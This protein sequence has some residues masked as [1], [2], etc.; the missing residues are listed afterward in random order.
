[1]SSIPSGF[2]TSFWGLT[3]RISYLLLATLGV[4]L[5]SVPLFSQGTFGRILGT[6]T[7]QSGGV[8][9]GA[10]VTIIDKDRG[11]AR[12]LTSDDAGEY[13]APNLTPGTYIVRVEANGFKKLERENVELGVGKEVRV[14]LT[15]QPGTQAQTV[16]VTEAIPLVE[17]TNATLGGTLNNEQIIDL[18]LNGR[19]YQNLMG[20]RPGVLLQPGGSPWTQSTNGGRP[21]QTAWMIEGVINEAFFDARPLQG[22]PSPF[23]DGATIVPIDA[24]QEFNMQE[25]PKAEYGWRPGAVVNVG[26]KNGT[27]NLHGTAYAFGRS[28]ALDARNAFNENLD[29][30][31]TCTLNGEK[32]DTDGVCN[33]A[34]AQLKQFGGTV[35]GPIKKDKLFFFAGY[36]GLRSQIGNIFILP[37]PNQGLMAQAIAKVQGL[38]GFSGTCGA[39]NAG[40]GTNRPNPC[41]S[42]VSLALAGCTPTGAAYTC[43]GGGSP[44]PGGTFVPSTTGLFGEQH[45][46]TSA[47]TTYSS[48][49]PNQNTS[50]NGIFK[51]DYHINNKNSLTAS[52]LVGNYT[53][54]GEDHPIANSYWRD[55]VPIRAQTYTG[56][57]IF[58]PSSNWVNDLRVA[59]DR[60]KFQI[61]PADTSLLANG[62]NYPLNTGITSTGG[63][64]TVYLSGAS[65]F[66]VAGGFWLGSWRGR[67]LITGP[68]PYYDLQDSVSYLRGK[69]SFK[70]GGEFAHI[71]VDEAPS[72][73]RGRFDIAGGGGPAAQVQTL[74][75]FFSG[76]FKDLQQI[77]GNTGRKLH[78][79]STAGFIQ[80]DYR[81]TSKLM[82]NLGLRYSYESPFKDA[83][84]QL[85][86]FDPNS[87]TGLVQQGQSGVN[88]ILNPDR[89]D[90][91]PRLGFAWDVTGKG[92]TV[93]RGGA[94]IIY[95][96]WQMAAFL[97]NPGPSGGHDHGASLALD[98]TG[99]SCTVGPGCPNGTYGGNITTGTLVLPGSSVHWDSSSAAPAV[100][101]APSCI[102]LTTGK[103]VCDLG[104]VDP[105]MKYPYVINWNLGVTHAFNPNLSLELGYVG[106]HGDRLT[107]MRD[108]NQNEVVNGQTFIDPVTGNPVQPYAAQFPGFRYINYAYGGASSNYDGL[109]TTL[110]Q[111]TSHG[112]SFTAG[113][114]YSHALDNGSLN[115]FGAL[116]Q[117]GYDLLAE[118]GS[119]DLDVRHHFTFTAS[120]D[121][122]GKK[123]FGQMLEGWKLNTVV[124]LQ[125][126]LPWGP[127][128][129][130]NDFENS[131]PAGGEET[132]RW[133]F[134]GNPADFK[135]P[136]SSNL[137]YCTGPG[138]GGCTVTSGISGLVTPFSDAQSTAMW[139]QCVAKA[140]DPAGTL[141]AGGCFVSGNSVM[142][143]PA[144]NHFGNMGRN[145]FRD[146]GFRDWDFSVFKNFRFT[147]RFGAQFRFEVF[148]LL[149]HP[150]FANPYG[151]AAG[152]LGSD[153]ST[154]S[155]FGCGCTTPDVGNGNALL[156]SGSARV[157]QLGLKLSF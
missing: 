141:A 27:N 7:D 4:L 26:L 25:N 92:T 38:P 28:D 153:P 156:G 90:F 145:L 148:N 56:D 110:T 108:L 14:D 152:G 109:Q 23:T 19:L 15:V 119:S 157:M 151:A 84:N 49:F 31:G 63:M 122:P 146:A 65:G 42:P 126:G 97:A 9:S 21:D 29:P 70:F 124:T 133:D 43:L 12:T 125:S 96:G 118:Y 115:R 107:A 68:S 81:L 1:M 18:P 40:N 116:P 143:P 85:G 67:P 98:P 154:A 82:I 44:G 144:A 77:I 24:I 35:G 58:T 66:G 32:P 99:F 128:D 103:P 79:T 88:S 117:N 60:F 11:V 89:K 104:A 132:T 147:E 17:T 59:Y 129:T 30:T 57:W 71:E 6:V 123:G 37:L 53:S 13:N 127:L 135:S 46:G 150:I 55:T 142:T 80:D 76:N 62:T 87:P 74:E 137:P 91:S 54:E 50:D 86:N 134:F 100:P 95:S 3:S 155:A 39:A 113:Y 5:F 52:A 102:S 45:A 8:I 48:N 114:T 120:Y 101:A 94:S 121:I 93:V 78:W 33:K 112:L 36:E 41:L 51:L 111:R 10:T 105:N 83:N 2:R 138:A 131:G 75:D 140:A 106:N 34:Q 16:T 149:N 136:G 130:G 73:T 72:D 20:L 64:P 47:S 139:N 22:T 61:I 69:H